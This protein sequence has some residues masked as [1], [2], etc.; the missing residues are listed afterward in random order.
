MYGIYSV[1][2]VTRGGT[3][4]YL[5]FRREARISKSVLFGFRLFDVAIFNAV[6]NGLNPQLFVLRYRYLPRRI[7]RECL[8]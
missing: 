5:L 2:N 4:S 7:A 1:P 3:G 6:K 8:L